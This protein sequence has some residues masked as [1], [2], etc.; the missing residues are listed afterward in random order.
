MRIKPIWLALLLLCASTV[1]FAQPDPKTGAMSSPKKPGIK[2]WSEIITAEAKSD[3]GVFNVYR[4]D[5]KLFYEIPKKKLNREFLL[6][7]RIAKTPQIGYG[8]EE[9][10]SEVIRWERKFDKILLRTLSY[11]NVAADSLPISKAVHNANFEEII[12]AYPIQCY[13]KDSSAVVIEVTSLFTTDIGIL[14]PPK[15][16][17][18]QYKMSMLSSDRSYI[19]YCHSYPINIEVENVL[20]YAADAAP[21][22]PS[23]RTISLAMHH[24]MVELPEKPMTPRLQD[25]RVGFFATSKVDYGLDVQRA[26]RRAYI[27]RWRLEPKDSAAYFRGEL[28]EPIKAITYYID[29][30]TPMKWRPWLRKGIESW[31]VAFEKAGFKNAVRVLDPPDS[32]QDPEFCPEDARYSVIRYFPS[33]VENAY[34]PQVHDPRSGEILESDIGWFHNVMNLQKGWYFTQAIADPRAHKLPLPDSL[35]GEL[36]STVA[37]HE[38]GHTIGFPHNMKASSSYAVDS[39]RSPSFTKKF[40]TAPSI[41]DYARYNYVA[42]P[43]DGAAL[44]PQVGPYDYFAVNWG[45]RVLPSVRKTED[46]TDSLN[47]WI[48]QQDSNPMLRYGQQQWM[49][50]DPSAQMEDLGDDAVKASTYGIKNLERVLGYLIDATTE[51]GKDYDLLEEM[52]NDVMHQWRNEVTH[53]AENIGGVVGTY[54]NAGQ[55]GVVY[56]MVPKQKQ[57]NCLAFLH[58]YVFKTPTM[59]LNPEILR[60][61]EANGSADRLQR[62][63]ERVLSTTLANDKLLRL[64]EYNSFDPSNYSVQALFDD[65][66][67]GLFEEF[68]GAA[69][70]PDLYRRNLQRSFVQ[71][72]VTKLNPPPPMQVGPGMSAAFVALFTPPNVYRTDIH[73]L[74]RQQMEG[75]KTK[76]QKVKGGDN[77]TQAHLKDLIRIL[78]DALNPKK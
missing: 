13:N 73:A 27:T 49:T 31:N 62:T 45:Y 66:Q 61:I 22:N 6:V 36:I 21:Q 28:V 44:Q 64:H 26:E 70:N 59:F 7:T 58:Q 74:V 8:G 63:Q 11:V 30:A 9:S 47:A 48:R 4:I 29:P 42:Q 18:D 38:F 19:D 56:E 23:S 46:E 17:R 71:L 41:M 75:L 35:M 32:T 76:L 77:M 15:S 5:D 68:A 16:Q 60:R 50:V 1:V 54:K 2:A 43:G 25:W 39:L 67:N 53:V 3:S 51:N 57:Q 12:A 52:Y 69:S 78:D 55:N 20:T 40:G 10:N 65:V 37:A 72:M 33:P 14:T 24:S 34:G